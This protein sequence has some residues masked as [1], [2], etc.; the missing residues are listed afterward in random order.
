MELDNDGEVSFPPP[1]LARIWQ[2][3]K[4]HQKYIQVLWGRMLRR[5]LSWSQGFPSFCPRAKA[6][7]LKGL[8]LPLHCCPG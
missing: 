3:R 8:F 5:K 4:V 2:E 1:R 6:I 7:L